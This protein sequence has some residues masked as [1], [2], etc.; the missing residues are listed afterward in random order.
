MNTNKKLI[1]TSIVTLTLAL[2]PAISFADTSM[3]PAPHVAKSKAPKVVDPAK[4]AYRAALASY[5]SQMTAYKAAVAANRAAKK[6]ARDALASALAAA[7]TPAEKEA[8]KAAH[9][10][11]LAAIAPLPTKP[12]RPTAPAGMGKSSN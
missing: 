6:S 2:T 1:S 4:A 7:K 5:K 8:A 3:S 12:V 9:T 10:A 11:A